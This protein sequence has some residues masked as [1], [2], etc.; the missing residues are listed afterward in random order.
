MKG[1]AVSESAPIY[2]E[3]MSKVAGKETTNSRLP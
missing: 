2:Y 3:E 1:G